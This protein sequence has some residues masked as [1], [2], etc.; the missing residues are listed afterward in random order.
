MVLWEN[1]GQK[2]AS[3]KIERRDM[4]GRIWRP[5][6]LIHAV[7]SNR[8]FDIQ[9]KGRAPSRGMPLVTALILVHV[10]IFSRSLL[11]RRI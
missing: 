7:E 10:L 5:L 11:A 8:D 4:E 1:A 3:R 2:L 9:D 6:C